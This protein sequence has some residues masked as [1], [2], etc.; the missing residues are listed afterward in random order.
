MRQRLV[1]VM[2]S[3]SDEVDVFMSLPSREGLQFVFRAPLIRSTMLLDFFSNP[4][5]EVLDLDPVLARGHLVG[6][7]ASDRGVLTW[8][9]VPA[10][11]RELTNGAALL[12]ERFGYR[13]RLF[14]PPRRGFG[15]A[16]FAT[17]RRIGVTA[18]LPRRYR[19]DQT[20][21]NG[22]LIELSLDEPGAAQACSQCL[23]ALKK[24]NLKVVA[25]SR[26][27]Q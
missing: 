18:V 3:R 22:A 5:L 25:L 15:A 7:A 26:F 16:L 19:L 23:Q 12:R 14:V 13:P 24:Q 27:E 17:A 8:L 10:M 4:A 11:R 21:P 2:N 9:T 20:V 6:L 1:T